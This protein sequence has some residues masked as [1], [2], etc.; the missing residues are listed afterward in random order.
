MDWTLAMALEESVTG[1]GRVVGTPLP[2]GGTSYPRLSCPNTF[3]LCPLKSCIQCVE[4]QLLVVIMCV[5]QSVSLGN[6][7]CPC[8]H[9]FVSVS[10]LWVRMSLL[11][12]SPISYNL[13]ASA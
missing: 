5:C 2:S 13:S 11:A 3:P 7:V 4:S 8:T 6:C 1:R 9:M 12:L 10:S